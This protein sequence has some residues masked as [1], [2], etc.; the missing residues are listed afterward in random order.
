VTDVGVDITDPSVDLATL[1]RGFGANAFRVERLSEVGDYVRE[2]LSSGQPCLL[3]LQ[4]AAPRF[5]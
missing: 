5:G 1:A 3:D 2:A 4:V